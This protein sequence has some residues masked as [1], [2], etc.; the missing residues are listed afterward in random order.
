MG[1]GWPSCR[2]LKAPTA[3]PDTQ[4]V[5]PATITVSP[6]V[7]VGVAIAVPVVTGIVVGAIMNPRGPW[8][9]TFEVAA[10][11]TG[12]VALVIVV[13]IIA[14][15]IAEPSSCS[16]GHCNDSDNAA[17]VQTMF[18]VVLVPLLYPFVLVGAA[19]GKLLGRGIRRLV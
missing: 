18:A 10:A 19:V 15:L 5:I 8:R 7:A 13:A 11:G 14:A 9:D 3:P 16:N 1:A 17:G 4:R 6:A 12:V 2:Q